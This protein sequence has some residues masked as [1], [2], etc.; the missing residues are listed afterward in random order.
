MIGFNIQY[1]RL[2]GDQKTGLNYY[3]DKLGS[4]AH[5]VIDEPPVAK[6]LIDRYPEALIL[7]RMT[8]INGVRDDGIHKHITPAAF[9]NHYASILPD[10]RIIIYA[11]NEPQPADDPAL[12]QWLLDVAKEAVN[13]GYRICLGNFSVGTPHETSP[14]KY[15]ALLR[16]AAAN[17]GKVYIGLHEYMLQ[18]WQAHGNW[19]LGRFNFWLDYCLMAGITE[20]D[21]IITEFG[22]DFIDENGQRRGGPIH[23]V[24]G[25]FQA[26]GY[27][28]QTSAARRILDAYKHHY[29]GRTAIKGVCMFTWGADTDEW[30]KFDVSVLRPFLDYLVTYKPEPI[31][32]PSTMFTRI[33][34][35]ALNFRLQPSTSSAVLGKLVEGDKVVLTGRYKTVGGYIWY[36]A[37][38]LGGSPMLGWFARILDLLTSPPLPTVEEPKPEEPQPETPKP[39][40][41]QTIAEIKAALLEARASLDKAL[42]RLEV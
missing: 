8:A 20:P 42:N 23:Q 19:H 21:F 40:I 41:E 17:K 32:L 39:D 24:I 37:R 16:Y 1:R 31:P 25:E 26:A 12:I 22:Y 27:E 9:I 30:V 15:D 10:K 11:N 6:G 18:D 28:G 34:G 2:N 5:V 13:R 29:H 3:A 38:K 35:G 36:E 4:S 33:P 7:L 14:I